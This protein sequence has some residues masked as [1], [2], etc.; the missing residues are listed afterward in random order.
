MI[1]LVC[2]RICWHSGGDILKY[3]NCNQKTI[4]NS[5]YYFIGPNQDIYAEKCGL[6]PKLRGAK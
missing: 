2:D 6:W 4:S 1:P 5:Y 3:D